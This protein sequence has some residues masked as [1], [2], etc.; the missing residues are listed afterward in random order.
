MP[1]MHFKQPGFTYSTCG[2]LTKNQIKNTK[3]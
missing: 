1:K 3:I 2:S